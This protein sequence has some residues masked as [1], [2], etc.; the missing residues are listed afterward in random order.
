MAWLQMIVRCFW[1]VDIDRERLKLATLGCLSQSSYSDST[2]WQEVCRQKFYWHLFECVRWGNFSQVMDTRSWAISPQDF[3]MVLSQPYVPMLLK[4][5][6]G[7]Q[8]W[9]SDASCT[10]ED[11]KTLAAATRRLPLHAKH[12]HDVS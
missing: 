12:V 2:H 6:T 4:L 8:S 3:R 7:E 9:R 10:Q 11:M 5:R 1:D